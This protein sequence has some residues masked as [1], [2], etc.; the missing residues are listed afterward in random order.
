MGT[1]VRNKHSEIIRGSCG[2]PLGPFPRPTVRAVHSCC[3]FFETQIR[4][5]LQQIAESRAIG[6]PLGFHVGKSSQRRRM[7]MTTIWLDTSYL[8]AHP[9]NELPF[10]L[11]FI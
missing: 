3:H 8:L 2:Q 7:E 1:R 4:T 5:A 9:L 11:L 6:L 10:T